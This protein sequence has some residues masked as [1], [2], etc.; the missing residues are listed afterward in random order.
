MAF[1]KAEYRIL[2][3]F[4]AG[5]AACFTGVDQTTKIAMHL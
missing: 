1:L 2:I 3:I 4:V 5:V